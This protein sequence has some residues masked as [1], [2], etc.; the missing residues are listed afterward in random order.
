MKT[1]FQSLIAGGDDLADVIHIDELLA[2]RFLGLAA[3]VIEHVVAIKVVLVGAAIEFH[4][5][6][7]LFLDVRRAGGGGKGGQPVFVRD[8]AVERGAGREMAGP[9]HEADTR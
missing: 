2:R 7:E 4:A 1:I 5:L 9:A 3:Q 8:D 6:E